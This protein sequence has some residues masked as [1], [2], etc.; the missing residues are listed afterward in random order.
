MGFYQQRVSV[1]RPVTVTDPYNPD[2][3]HLSYDQ[4]D[5]ATATAVGFGVDMQP[6]LE[7]E[8]GAEEG[9]I[10]TQT[11][12]KLFTPPGRDLD[13]DATCRIRYRGRDLDIEGEVRRWDSA[14][15]PSGVDHVS[16]TLQYV[17]G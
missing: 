3:G 14:D 8:L 7:V 5:G 4:T 17:T 11:G 6:R 1:I 13:V 10:G 12:W 9:R 2:G 15:Y 16:L